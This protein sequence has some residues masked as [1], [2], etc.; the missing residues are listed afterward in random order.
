LQLFKSELKFG[1]NDIQFR[2]KGHHFD[3]IYPKL[4]LY[5]DGQPLEAFLIEHPQKLSN[6]REVENRSFFFIN[7]DLSTTV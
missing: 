6:S 7:V 3:L 2:L 5:Y 1:D 4:L